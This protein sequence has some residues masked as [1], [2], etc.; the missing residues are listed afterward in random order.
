MKRFYFSLITILTLIVNVCGFLPNAFANMDRT[1]IQQAIDFVKSNNIMTG[2]EDGAFHPELGLTRCELV[3]VAV[4]VTNVPLKATA[5]VKSFP[6]LP[7][8]NW[9]TPYVNVTSL[10]GY[11]D[12]TFK[13]NRKVTQIEALK[14]IF[15]S[16][17]FLVDSPWQEINLPFS[18]VKPTDWWAPYIK[19]GIDKKIIPNHAGPKFGIQ[20]EMRRD[21]VAFI[22]WNIL[23]PISTSPM[24]GNAIN[25]DSFPILEQRISTI[26]YCLGKTIL[27]G[28]VKSCVGKNTLVATDASNR[29]YVIDTT[30]TADRDMGPVLFN[31][32]PEITRNNPFVLISYVPRYFA[33]NYYEASAERDEHMMYKMDPTYINFFFDILSKQSKRIENYPDGAQYIDQGEIR[34]IGANSVDAYPYQ[35]L[36]IYWSNTA[37]KA[38]FIPTTCEMMG[39]SAAPLMGYDV[40]TDQVR[41][42]TEEK[43]MGKTLNPDEFSDTT[44]YWAN[45]R[46]LSNN[47]W[48][49]D[50]ISADGNRRTVG[51]TF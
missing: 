38:V 31:I 46:S 26:H 44:S 13:P 17:G 2:S 18:D 10:N 12:G 49:A 20:D 32:Q 42:I 16:T 3:K 40:A 39:C 45:I 30:D 34:T 4:L 19:H 1:S 43:A 35:D 15:G 29:A 9:C 24:Y 14:I 21:E 27:N 22:L 5:V 48:S 7:S 28:G 36:A 33:P 11:P 25:M 51:F 50:L 6:D 41:P 47:Q 23:K 8:D 37:F